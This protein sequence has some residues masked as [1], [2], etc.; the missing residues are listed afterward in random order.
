[1]RFLANMGVSQLVIEWLKSSGHDAVHLREHDLQR[2]KDPDILAKARAEDRILLAMDLDFGY[3]LASGGWQTPTTIIFR[4]DDETA[5][6]VIRRLE[7]VLKS[8]RKDLTAG[9]V[10]SV[11]QDSIRVRRLPV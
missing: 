5:D 8:C 3:L 10:L 9:A 7:E 6:S 2:M 1:V 11:R 4:L